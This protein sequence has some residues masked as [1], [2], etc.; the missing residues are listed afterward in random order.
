MIYTKVSPK[1][2]LSHLQLGCTG[3]HALNLLALHNEMQRYHLKVEGISE[4]I[5]MLKE[6]QRQAGRA[7]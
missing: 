6:S 4:Y 2:L 1:D 5:N 7:G 3:Q